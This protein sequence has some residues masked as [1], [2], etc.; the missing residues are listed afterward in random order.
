MSSWYALLL[1]TLPIPWIAKLL[2]PHK[3]KWPEVAITVVVNVIVV[4]TLYFAGTVGMTVDHEIWNGEITG[5]DRKHGSYVIPYPCNCSTSCQTC[6]ED[7]YTVSWTA[8]STIGGFIV[9]HLDRSSRSVYNT[10]DPVRYTSINVGDPCS[11]ASTF[12]NYVKAVPE[13]LFHANPLINERFKTMVPSYPGTIYDIYKVDRVLTV[14]VPLPEHAKWNHDLSLTLRKLGPQKQA[15]AIIVFVN[16]AD[17]SYIHALESAWLGGKKNDIIIVIGT[18]AYP[19][20]DWVAVSS[21]SKQELFKVQLR[22][23]IYDLGEVKRADV[24]RLI[25]THVTSGYTRRDM[26]DFEYLKDEIEPP[27]WLLILAGILGILS[28]LGASYYFYRE[29]PFTGAGYGSFNHLKRFK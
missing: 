18:T 8:Q 11:R 7:R 16:T 19:K 26:A 10:P 14:G 29:D 1:F 5:K 15:N 27:M 13:S 17:Q 2:W 12:T 28:S 24:M 20:I 23:A 3:I 6:Y 9:E 21:W 22:D 4:S 25:D